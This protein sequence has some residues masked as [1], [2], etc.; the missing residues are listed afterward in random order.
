MKKHLFLR[1]CLM[2]LVGVSAF[3]CRTEEF[4]NEEEAHGNPGL[5][6]TFKRISLNEAK[7]RTQLVPELQKAE[8]GIKA[9]AQ[10][11]AKGKINYADGVS[12]DTDQVTY[13]ENGPNFHTYTFHLT[14]QNALPTDPIENLVL[15]PAT[16]G[17][18]RE[19]LISYNLTPQE[20]QLMM[21][22]EYVDTQ[23]KTTVTLL[24]G[25]VYNPLGAKSNQSCVW[26]SYIVGYTAC[27]KN[28]H[29]NGEGSNKC[30][31]IIKSKPI[32]EYYLQCKSIAEAP[33]DNGWWA[34]P[35]GG[36]N[37]GGGDCSSCPAENPTPEPEPCNG[38]GVSI[39]PVDPIGGIAEGGCE[40]IPTVI[41]FPDPNSP[42]NK[43]KSQFANEN[44]K[45][46]VATINKNYNFNLKKETGFSENKDGTFTD[47]FPPANNSSDAL[48]I[49]VD[50]N[51]KGY[52]HVHVNDRTTS[53]LTP[54]GYVVINKKI[55]MFSPADVDVLMALANLNKSPENFGDLY[56][57]MLSS[58]GTYVIK[59]TG[60][61]ADI[62]MGFDTEYWRLEYQDY[63]KREE[64]NTQTKF[65]RF[66]KNKMLI[67]GVSLYKV[68]PNGKVFE[69]KLNAAQN[70]AEPIECGN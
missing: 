53:D 25:M 17:S 63:F 38:N 59:F 9:F 26:Q 36:T 48:T 10:K 6:L 55:R 30:D 7:H 49:T 20:K 11:N 22:G 57:T 19:M 13:I 44:Y 24:D 37:S 35:G 32:K 58:D 3:S 39:Q 60:T 18:Y 69:Y 45:N 2:F 70:D 40:G 5:R 15:I 12:I 67:Q 68:K 27:S 52:T 31:A 46:K 1:L 42:C 66:M 65:L 64:G 54:E 8:I 50:Q 56:G 29:F 33:I 28:A 51:T 14:R 21:A 23:D 47:L 34:G 61:A 4:H 16:D 41:E 62:K 43:V